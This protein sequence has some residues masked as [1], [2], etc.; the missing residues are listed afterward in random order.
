MGGKGPGS[1]FAVDTYLARLAVHLMS[2]HFCDI[3]ANVINKIESEFPRPCLK[4]LLEGLPHPVG[5]QLTI[6]EGKIG[7]TGHSRQV[8]L[9]FL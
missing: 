4:N 1:P 3:V 8:L 2:L 9:A 7:G 5:D 6:A